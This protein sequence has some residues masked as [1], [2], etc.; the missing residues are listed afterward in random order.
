MY[1]DIIKKSYDWEKIKAHSEEFVFI[2]SD[3][4]PWGCDDIQGRRMLDKLGGVQIVMK[5]EGHMG[6]VSR[7]QPYK[8]FPLLKKIIL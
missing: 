1:D 4:D 6:S 2:N 5:G 7:N 8:E 3:N